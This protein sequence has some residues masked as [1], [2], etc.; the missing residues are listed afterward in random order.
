MWKYLSR[1]VVRG[2]VRS[3]GEFEFGFCLAPIAKYFI[4]RESLDRASVSTNKCDQRSAIKGRVLI[5]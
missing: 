2:E 4:I 1:V 3:S 5:G